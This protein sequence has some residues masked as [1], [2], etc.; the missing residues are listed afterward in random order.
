L[1]LELDNV[2]ASGETAT[3]TDR[4]K[5]AEG[6]FIE[7][8]T[9]AAQRITVAGMRNGQPLLRFRANWYCAT[10]IEPDWT[11]GETGWRVLVEGDTPFDISIKLPPTAESVAEQMGGYTA[12]RAVN[13]VPYVCAARPGI[14]TI[15]DMPQI[16]ARL[17]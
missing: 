16:I 7:K 2:E 10:E 1:S 11:L 4:V 8:G 13:A 17:S 15:A 5:I 12:H 3:A 14:V 6:A 9:V